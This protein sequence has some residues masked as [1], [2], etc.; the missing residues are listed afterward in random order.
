MLKTAK[1]TAWLTILII[2]LAV[3]PSAYAEEMVINGAGASFPFPIY[4]KWAYRYYK[5]TSTK[6]N[7]LSI[8]S[9]GGIAQI[10]SNTID[11]GASDAPLLPAELEEYGLVQFPLIIGGIV[12]VY[13]E[14]ITSSGLKLTGQVLSDIFLHKI[15]RWNDPKIQDL[16]PDRE[17]PDKEITVVH[18]SDPSG[19]TWIFTNYLSKVSEDWK[20]GIGNGK[21]VPWPSGIGAKGNEGAATFV[22]RIDGAIGY[23]EFAYAVQNNLAFISLQNKSGNFVSPAIETFQQAAENADWQNSN[24]YYVVLTDQPGDKSWPITGASFILMR[25]HQQSTE[26]AKALLDFFAWCYENGDALAIE[27]DY[28]PIPDSVVAI[29]NK[30][31]ENDIKADGQPVWNY[32]E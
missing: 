30:M 27:L 29:I 12:P 1:T 7:Y 19:S 21:A 2:H 15:T 9:G 4:S 31:W 23:V 24:Q 20:S 16:N 3:S 13:N 26:K 28:I 5:N 8:G 11:F 25:K 10:K 22:Q 32:D 6:I 17:L 18:R 14:S